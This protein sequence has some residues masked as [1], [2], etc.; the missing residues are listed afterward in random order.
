M[1]S[2]A[3]YARQALEL[4]PDCSSISRSI[5]SVVT[6]ILGDA[7][8][9]NGEMEEAKLA[10]TEA[11]RIGREANNLHMVIIANTSIA[12]ILAVQGQLHRAADVYTQCLQS[13]VR[14]DG[15]RSP[16]AANIFVSMAKLFYEWNRLDDADLYVHQCI[17]LS[18]CKPTPTPSGPG[19]NKPGGIPNK[20]RK[21]S[22]RQSG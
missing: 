1:H 15:Q 20:P 3:E 7:S 2:A 13:A 11:V 6:S 9:F 5:R 19:S 14:P 10:Y 8:W 16:L 22:V 17:D 12:D 4:L 21:P 18:V